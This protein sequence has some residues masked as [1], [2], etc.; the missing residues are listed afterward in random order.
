VET[1]ESRNHRFPGSSVVE[2]AGIEPATSCLQI[3][4]TGSSSVATP[5]Q[6]GESEDDDPDLARSFAVVCGKCLP[7]ACPLSRR[8]PAK[9]EPSQR[10]GR[11]SRMDRSRKP[12]WAFSPS[13]VR[14]PPSPLDTADSQAWPG[15][16]PYPGRSRTHA[17]QV[18]SG[19]LRPHLPVRP[20]PRHSPHGRIDDLTSVVSDDRAMRFV[21]PRMADRGTSISKPEVGR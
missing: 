4:T 8:Q 2:P 10:P 7:P 14:I 12:V 13:G 1:Y 21:G 19:Q 5:D 20:S 16:W 11:R 18:N 9:T 6:T 15:V 17:T 3:R